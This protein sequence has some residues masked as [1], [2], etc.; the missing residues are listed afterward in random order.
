MMP[1]ER[2]DTPKDSLAQLV[3]LYER[4]LCWSLTGDEK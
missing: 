3:I 4:Q 1:A 2:K